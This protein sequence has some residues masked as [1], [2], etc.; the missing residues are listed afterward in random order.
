MR[1]CVHMYRHTH[2]NT[3]IKVFL[4]LGSCV[5]M[6]AERSNFKFNATRIGERTR[7]K[8]KTFLIAEVNGY[9]IN[10]V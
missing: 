7:K 5:W 9:H 3:A 2:T 10:G 8:T 1:V 4:R 6:C